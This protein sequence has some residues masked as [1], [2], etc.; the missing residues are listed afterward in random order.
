MAFSDLNEIYL[1]SLD[2]IH[3][4][5]EAL[6][7][8]SCGPSR[9]F[10]ITSHEFRYRYSAALKRPVLFALD[11]ALDFRTEENS[12]SI[13]FGPGPGVMQTKCSPSVITEWKV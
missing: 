12:K 1:A 13:S 3:T 4:G 11:D 5:L 6:H 10:R 8:E 7:D 2:R 9:K